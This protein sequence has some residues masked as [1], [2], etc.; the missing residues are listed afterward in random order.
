MASCQLH[1]VQLGVKSGFFIKSL[2]YFPV[3]YWN[4]SNDDWDIDDTTGCF[5]A[6]IKP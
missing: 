5:L 4:I 1:F 2:N 3:E 6:D